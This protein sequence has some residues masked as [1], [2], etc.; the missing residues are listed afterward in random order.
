[1]KRVFASRPYQILAV[2]WKELN[3]RVCKTRRFIEHA[4]IGK[5]FK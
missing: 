5:Y 4:K 3:E 1:M 2:L